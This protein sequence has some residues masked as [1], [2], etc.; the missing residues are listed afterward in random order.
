M[1]LEVGTVEETNGE[2]AAL[3]RLM[4]QPIS[5]LVV[6]VLILGTAL[7]LRAVSEI[8]VQLL[9]GGFLALI[10]W[11]MYGAM[12]RAKLPSSIALALTT[13]VVL[14][15]VIAAERTSSHGPSC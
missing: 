15:V 4:T 12:R 6:L 11:P 8:A 10:A 2:V 13:L 1:T 5:G 7:L 14:G 3:D 9:C